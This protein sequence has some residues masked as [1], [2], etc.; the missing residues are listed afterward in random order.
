MAL[1]VNDNRDRLLPGRAEHVEAAYV[2]ADLPG[3]H[4]QSAVPG[5]DAEKL[6]LDGTTVP[7]LGGTGIQ[8]AKH[9]QYRGFGRLV[10]RESPALY[11]RR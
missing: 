6:A 8:L 4:Q 9:H 2:P 1:P 7:V 10:K 11:R 5:I 3:S